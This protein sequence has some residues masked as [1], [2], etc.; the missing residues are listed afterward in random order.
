MRIRTIKPE[1]WTDSFMVNLPPIARLIFISLWSAADDHGLV[2]DEPERIA[3]LL[4]PKEDWTVFDDWLQF[5]EE[6]NR[7]SLMSDDS[8]F[9][10]YQINNWEKHQRVDRPSKSRIFREGSRKVSVPLAV[11]RQVAEKY[12]CPPGGEVDAS[13]YYCGTHGR[14]VWHKLSNGSPSSWVTFPGLELEHLECLSGGGKNTNDNIVLSCRTC[15]RSKGTREWADH[16]FSMD[17]HENSRAF[18][19]PVVKNRLDQGTGIRDQGK[20]QGTGKKPPRGRMKYPDEFEKLWKLYPP[21][22]GTK[23]G[24]KAA[25]SQYS[26][27]LKKVEHG[28]IEESLLKFRETKKA[29]SGYPQDMFRW[30]KSEPWDDEIVQQDNASPK[31][32]QHPFMDGLD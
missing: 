20:D 28:L 22:G 21:R 17:S 11:R 23:D 15:N 25:F 31:A 14:I 5:F 26:L 24:K 2:Q 13:C 1:F 27:A 16:M 10:F 32:Q 3:M 12:N 18:E 4:M 7:I 19:R 8:G 6:T 30:L 9:T 29:K